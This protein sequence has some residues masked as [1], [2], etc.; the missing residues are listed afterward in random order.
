MAAA[1][2]F[3]EIYDSALYQINSLFIYNLSPYK[4]IFEKLLV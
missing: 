4:K 1:Q 3:A 2:L